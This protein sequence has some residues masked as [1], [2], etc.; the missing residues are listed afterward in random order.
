MK[1]KKKET[2]KKIKARPKGKTR[3]SSKKAGPGRR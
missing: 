3:P 1:H 2:K